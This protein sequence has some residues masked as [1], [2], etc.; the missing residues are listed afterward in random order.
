MGRALMR[1]AIEVSRR[2]RAT[3]VNIKPVARDDSAIQVFHDLGFRT[4]GR[5]QLF[6]SLDGD[7]SMCSPVPNATGAHSTAE[8]RAQRQV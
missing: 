7:R 3:G 5:L 4:L 6:M 2:R 8:H 1:T